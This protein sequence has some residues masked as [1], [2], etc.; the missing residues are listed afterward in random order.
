MFCSTNS[1]SRAEKAW[2]W[3]RRK[4]VVASLGSATLVLLVAVAVGAPIAAFRINHERQRAEKEQSVTRQNLY[5]ADM[6]LVQRAV[7]D[8]NYGLGLRLLDAHRPRPGQEEIRGWEWRYF[9]KL[10]QGE[11]LE[12]WRG[13]SNFVSALAISPD[14]KTLASASWDETVK[15]WDLNTGRPV[16][17]LREC[18]G[19][20]N[21]VSFSMDGRLLAAGSDAVVTVWDLAA[22]KV[23]TTIKSGR[24]TVVFS[25]VSGLLAFS[26]NYEDIKVLMAAGS[27]YEDIKN[28]EKSATV[29][30][31]A[32]RN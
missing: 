2:R 11:S 27:T 19:H 20:L 5:A 14:G 28:D 29:N 4:P 1:T 24:P 13:H 9:W 22:D 12:T 8:G 7:D 21:S 26:S 25:P 17:T 3:C 18:P 16:K 30:C 6:Y 32:A 15:L 31:L 10:C 23:L